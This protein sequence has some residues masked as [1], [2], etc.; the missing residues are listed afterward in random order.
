MFPVVV[1][2][3]VVMTLLPAPAAAVSGQP[4]MSATLSDR[5]LE[6][7]TQPTLAVSITNTGE[8]DQSGAGDAADREDVM[9]ARGTIA[10]LKAGDTPVTVESGSV[11][12]GEMSDGTQKTASFDVTVPQDAEPGTY[13]LSVEVAYKHTSSVISNKLFAEDTAVETVDLQIEIDSAPSFEV[14][15]VESTASAG[16]SGTVTMGIKNSGA[17]PAAGAA[18]SVSSSNAA[19]RFGGSST[20]S[21]FVASWGANETREVP[22]EA[23]F[24]SDAEQRGYPVT[25]DIEYSDADGVTR[26]APKLTAGVTPAPEQTF[27]LTETD[28]SLR[29]GQEGRLKGTLRNEGPGTI[30]NAVLVL[31]PVGA[32]IDAPETEFAIDA[33]APSETA[34]FSYSV[35]VSNDARDGP[36]Q[37]SYRVR[38]D[39][40]QDDTRES[41]ALFTRHAVGQ[42]QDLFALESNTTVTQG[43][44]TTMAVNMTNTGDEPLTDITAKMFTSGPI[45]VS[46]DEAFLGRLGA[47]ETRTVQFS[48][49]AD[50]GAAAKPYPVSIDV[51]YTEPDGDTKIS[52]SY[53]L[54]VEVG[55]S[56]GGG[57][58]AT[59][60]GSLGLIALAVGGGVLVLRRRQ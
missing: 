17:E 44:S 35:E 51:E 8:I 26:S 36:R 29:V 3:L 15:S 28:A 42:K 59:I 48:I 12:L 5:T 27:T 45:G 49:S 55:T 41:D 21:S 39:D 22:V 40:A 56:D 16:S 34:A 2:L 54:P 19:L 33:L 58:L 6:R 50:G 1:S 31:Q 10:T 7:G 23:T 24:A 38:Y 20:G 30:D 4:T 52:D 13:N 43:G 14:I 57:G 47:G 18:V 37:F 46:D 25:V 11:A 53:K 32:N 60:L 9:T